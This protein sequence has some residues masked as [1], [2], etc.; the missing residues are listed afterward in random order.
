MSK[1]AEEI[2]EKI[3]N[4]YKWPQD[5]A[6]ESEGQKTIAAMT[7]VIDEKLS[8]VREAIKDAMYDRDYDYNLFDFT[9]TWESIK[10]D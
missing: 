5:R 6:S 1:L 8:G 9:N 2:A 10:V 4:K 3:F 7:V